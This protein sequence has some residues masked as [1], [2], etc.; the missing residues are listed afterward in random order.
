MLVPLVLYLGA[1][2]APPATPATGLDCLAKNPAGSPVK[3]ILEL[4]TPRPKLGEPI[5][6]K[7]SMTSLSTKPVLYDDQSVAAHGGFRVVGSDGREAPYVGGMGQTA[8]AP[9]NL[10]PG[11]TVVLRPKVDLAE[12]YLLTR[13]GRYAICFEGAGPGGGS[14][15]FPGSNTV[16]VDLDPGAVPSVDLLA[17]QVLPVAPKGW[18][19]HKS[20]RELRKVTPD[21]RGEVEGCSVFLSQHAFAGKALEVFQT[22]SPTDVVAAPKG[23]RVTT[24]LGRGKRGHVYVTTWKKLP[25]V[26]PTAIADLRAALIEKH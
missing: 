21:G 7:L 23:G 4:L 9:E 24:Y 26:W 8:G 13:P 12:R 5:L 16:G 3:M 25:E 14:L 11:A 19:I 10:R 22:T 15:R 17:L 18:V 20:P 6:V 1:A 2:V